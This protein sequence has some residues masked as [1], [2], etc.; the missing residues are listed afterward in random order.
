MDYAALIPIAAYLVAVQL[1]TRTNTHPAVST[2][3]AILLPWLVSLALR[4]IFESGYG[5]VDLGGLF[6][7]YSLLLVCVQFLCGLVIFK[8]LRDEKSI[9][10][11]LAWGA[12]GF[13]VILIL[14]PYIAKGIVA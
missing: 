3:V 9:G 11:M 5:L 12:G 14:L 1:A 13:V 7:L 10:A 4:Y 2:C 8:Q 6:S